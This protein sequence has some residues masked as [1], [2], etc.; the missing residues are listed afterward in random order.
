M[1]D[2]FPVCASTTCHWVSAEAVTCLAPFVGTCACMW[3]CVRNADFMNKKQLLLISTDQH[4]TPF[5]GCSLS[6]LQMF[7]F[8]VHWI[9]RLNFNFTVRSYSIRCYLLC[10]CSPTCN[11]TWVLH[12]WLT[13]NHNTLPHTSLP[14]CCHQCPWSLFNGSDAGEQIKEIRGERGEKERSILI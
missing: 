10:C 5:R 13:G 7:F 11:Y 8:S 4:V 12:G 2:A 3:V 1:I 6:Q 14:P 9:L